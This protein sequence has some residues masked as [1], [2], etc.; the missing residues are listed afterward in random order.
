MKALFDAAKQNPALAEKMF[1]GGALGTISSLANTSG[2]TGASPA[3]A[4]KTT[5]EWF[6]VSLLPTFDQVS[7]YFHFSVNAATAQ[8]DG[9]SFK[10]F[11]PTPPQLRH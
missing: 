7:K 8:P 10:T 9:I 2:M 11:L 5:K 4:D 3:T 6:D 1:T